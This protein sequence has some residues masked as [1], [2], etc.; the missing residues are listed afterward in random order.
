[1]SNSIESDGCAREIGKC[2]GDHQPNGHYYANDV[3]IFYFTDG[4][5]NEIRCG[6]LEKGRCAVRILNL[7]D[8]SN[9]QIM[10]LPPCIRLRER[11][12]VDPVVRNQM[13]SR[14]SEIQLDRGS[15][16]F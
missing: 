8:L 13:P 11:Y 2:Y 7:R 15:P 1:M 5:P 16:Y 10:A 14:L 12:T 9:E 3:G 6:S 4:R